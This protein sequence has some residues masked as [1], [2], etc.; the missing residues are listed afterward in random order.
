MPRMLSLSPRRRRCSYDAQRCAIIGD[1]ETATALWFHGDG[2]PYT[3]KVTPT[4]RA[5]TAE[6][7]RQ[8]KCSRCG[9]AGGSP[10]WAYTGFTCFECGGSGKG[11]IRAVKVYI[12]DKVVKLQASAAKREVKRVAKAKEAAEVRERE[13]ATWSADHAAQISKIKTEAGNDTFISDLV[14]RMD[15][16]FTVLTAKQLEA[17]CA[18]V[19]RIVAKREA[20]AKRVYIG[21]MGERVEIEWTTDKVI[22]LDGAE[23]KWGQWARGYIVIGHDADG[24]HVKYFGSGSFPGEGETQKCRATV[25][26]HEEYRGQKQTTIGRPRWIEQ[27][28]HAEVV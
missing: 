23:R 18:A 16:H 14:Q 24:N 26:A 15:L 4:K 25:K 22:P 5:D 17:G 7:L 8:D 27:E 20:E 21:T 13:F 28:Q 3:G 6:Y 11:H 2:S 12:A 10:R 9:G 19:D 1:M